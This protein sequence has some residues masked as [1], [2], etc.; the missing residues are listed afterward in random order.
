MDV[1]N[2]TAAT[3][4]LLEDVGNVADGE[5]ARLDSLFH[6]LVVFN[7]QFENFVQVAEEP[8]Q[9]FARHQ[10]SLLAQGLVE[11][12]VQH[13][14]LADVTSLSVEQFWKKKH[15]EMV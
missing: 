6:F 11:K 13:F 5:S 3:Y 14:Q 10:G 8:V 12:Q 4:H 2:G 1:V 9:K 15:S 7:V